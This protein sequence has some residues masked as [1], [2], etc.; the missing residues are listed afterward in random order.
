[1][2]SEQIQFSSI[3]GP[4][5]PTTPGNFKERVKVPALALRSVEKASNGQGMM[6]SPT[7]YSTRSTSR[8]PRGISLPKLNLVRNVK[9][10]MTSFLSS[11]TPRIEG[12]MASVLR[13]QI[14]ESR[15][16][17]VAG[18]DGTSASRPFSARPSV[19]E[20]SRSRSLPQL[21][22]V[23]EVS[24]SR[25]SRDAFTRREPG[26]KENPESRMFREI[27]SQEVVTDEG[28]T[29]VLQKL[30]MRLYHCKLSDSDTSSVLACCPEVE[31]LAECASS[32]P[33]PVGWSH[34][35]V[36]E[37]QLAFINERTREIS[38]EPPN[39]DIFVRLAWCTIQVRMRPSNVSK[40]ASYV[41]KVA[42][43]N[44]Q[45]AQCLERCWTGPHYDSASGL[46][47]YYCPSADIS[48]WQ[49]PAHELLY[50]SRVAY[51]LLESSVFDA[52]GSFGTDVK[53]ATNKHFDTFIQE[54]ELETQ[55]RSESS[56][57]SRRSRSHSVCTR[58]HERGLST[59]PLNHDSDSSK[60]D[61]FR[62]SATSRSTSAS[63]GESRSQS[64][65]VQYVFGTDTPCSQTAASKD[66]GHSCISRSSSRSSSKSSSRSKGRTGMKTKKS[67]LTE[68]STSA[69]AGKTALGTPNTYVDDVSDSALDADQQ[70][71]KGGVAS[72]P[73]EP[74][75]CSMLADEKDSSF[76]KASL[77]FAPR[78]RSWTRTAA[79]S[80][81]NKD[82][83]EMFKATN[84]K[85]RGL[86]RNL[87][88]VL[89]PPLAK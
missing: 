38:Y 22:Q 72:A 86:H 47:Y 45:Q 6:A 15:S 51:S 82:V 43:N 64:Q 63:T 9:D 60:N 26:H 32:C 75:K 49:S 84:R 46:P 34:H 29:S 67:C 59:P 54:G 70:S 4:L 13:L 37:E 57:Q 18:V 77:V 83:L 25:L 48:S 2:S 80:D 28:Q 33:L 78:A 61:A 40:L 16:K 68:S 3:V 19:H 17:G 8:L 58:P 66:L 73:L 55:H 24:K 30:L 69:A 23:Q 74:H 21:K 56:R 41:H 5:A 87:S 20:L 12:R 89:L 1:M 14:T 11:R 88:S 62:I 39:L 44:A 36:N 85:S 79:T 53:M 65:E 7:G 35:Q 10:S 31:W 27:P 50:V 42:R 52:H 81:D 71:K 76:A